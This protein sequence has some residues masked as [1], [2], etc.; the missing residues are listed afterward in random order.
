MMGEVA[1]MLAETVKDMAA[2]AE[3]FQGK[4]KWFNAERGYGFIRHRNMDLFCHHTSIQMDGFRVLEAG[5][6]V[7]Y[8]IALN[9]RT[10]RAQAVD[11]RKVE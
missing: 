6:E 2:A 1:M 5:D 8:G 4:V 3:R 10:G 9:G 11:V 7:E